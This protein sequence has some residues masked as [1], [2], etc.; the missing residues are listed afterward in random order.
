MSEK[1]GKQVLSCDG[2]L[3]I[4][5]L[6]VISQKGKKCG[7]LR[8]VRTVLGDYKGFVVILREGCGEFEVSKIHICDLECKVR[9]YF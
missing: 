8:V 9:W 2:I 5:L 7:N 4:S 6:G 3:V 1:R